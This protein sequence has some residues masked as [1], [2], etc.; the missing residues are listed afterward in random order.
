MK[1]TDKISGFTVAI[2]RHGAK[3]LARVMQVPFANI[4]FVC[5]KEPFVMKND[6]A[7]IPFVFEEI[8]S[9][10]KFRFQQGFTLVELLTVVVVVGILTAIATPSL[11]TFVESNR[12]SAATNDFVTDLALARVEA[13]KR[14]EGQ[15]VLC[16]STNGTSCAAAPATWT[17]GWLVFWD[18]NS[19]NS[20]AAADDILLKA[21][22]ALPT[23]LATT[24]NPA[25]AVRIAYN[26]L[27]SA[28][29]LQLELRNT[30]TGKNRFVCLSAAGRAGAAK[31][32]AACCPG[33]GIC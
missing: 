33:M 27:G 13:L 22:P 9:V 1:H 8:P 5:L 28:G 2:G 3:L 11:Q 20:Y 10:E 29:A 30:K 31:E 18:K 32:G 19:S 4:P 16:V 6:T 17:S 24:S 23:Q 26:R 7:D 14:Q 25:N 12:L 21:H 15:V